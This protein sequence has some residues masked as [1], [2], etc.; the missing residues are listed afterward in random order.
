MDEIAG[1][2]K[3][4]KLKYYIIKNGFSY[5]FD[6][7]NDSIKEEEEIIRSFNVIK[8]IRGHLA[9]KIELLNPRTFFNPFLMI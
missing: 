2:N 9:V 3:H 8:S 5:L 6:K 7:I 1:K 4:Y